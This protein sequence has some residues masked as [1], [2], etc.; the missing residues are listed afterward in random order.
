MLAE[1]I[2]RWKYL[3]GDT[4]I[5]MDPMCYVKK[6]SDELIGKLAMCS[7]C[8]STFIVSNPDPDKRAI[9]CPG[10]VDGT[11]ELTL[12]YQQNELK[13]IGAAIH[14]EWFLAQKELNERKVK[15][16]EAEKERV[17]QLKEKYLSLVEEVDLE[18]QELCRVRMRV[19]AFLGSEQ[20]RIQLS[21]Q[22]IA[23]MT[24]SQRA[25]W[26]DKYKELKAKYELQLS[27]AKAEKAEKAEKVKPKTDSSKRLEEA[28][29][30]LLRKE[31]GM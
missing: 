22:H 8:D 6:R 29:A 10:C 15:E 9:N 25:K 16:I 28:I 27:A 20:K 18:N 24:R 19:Q 30:N 31:S 23:D 12:E 5:C 17:K 21:R 1:H 11:P 13:R 3:K 7:R 4:W 2:H 26:Q 14:E